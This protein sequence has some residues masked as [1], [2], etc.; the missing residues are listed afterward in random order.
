MKHKQLT[1]LV[2]LSVLFVTNSFAQR[3]N[4]SIKNSLGPFGGLTFSNLTTDN[5]ITQQGQGWTAGLT[6]IVNVEHKWYDVSY[7][8]QFTESTFGVSARETLT[9]EAEFVDYKI[10]GAQLGIML[11]AKILGQNRQNVTIDFGPLIQANGFLEP[12]ED[13]FAGYIVDGYETLSVKDIRDISK[14]NVLGAVG[15]T[16]GIKNFRVRGQ[17]QYGFLNTL[18]KLNDQELSTEEFKGKQTNLVLTALI[19]F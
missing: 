17:Y 18:A 10:S 13:S 9:S 19:L 16:I 7:G 14:F 4:Y 8:L 11:H 5:F 2:V 12:N 15:A 6:A 1:L 3:P